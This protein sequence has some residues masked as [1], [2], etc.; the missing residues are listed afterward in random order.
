MK[1]QNIMFTRTIPQMSKARLLRSA[2]ALGILALSCK[3]PCR[4]LKPSI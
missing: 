4:V 2:L 1:N 3:C